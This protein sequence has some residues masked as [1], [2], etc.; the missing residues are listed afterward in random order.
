MLQ[1]LMLLAIALSIAKA[2]SWLI[3]PTFVLIFCWGMSFFCWSTYSYAKGLG[4]GI[5]KQLTDQINELKKKLEKYEKE[6]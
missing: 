1:I 5:N 4:D 2:N 6:Q 3:V